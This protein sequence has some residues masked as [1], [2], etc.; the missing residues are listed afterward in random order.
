MSVYTVGRWYKEYLYGWWYDEYFG[1]MSVGTVGGMTS[2]YASS[3][4]YN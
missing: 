4:W 3:G 2:I 1:L